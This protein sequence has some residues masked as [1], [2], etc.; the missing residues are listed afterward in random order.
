MRWEKR[1]AGEGGGDPVDRVE[2]MRGRRGVGK[3]RKGRKRVQVGR[4]ASTTVKNER[5]ETLK[6]GVSESREDKRMG[7]CYSV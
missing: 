1:R 7:R 4:R 6:V 5:G 2:A 3:G